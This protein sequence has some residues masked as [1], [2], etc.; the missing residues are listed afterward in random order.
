MS[1]EIRQLLAVIDAAYDRRSWHGTNLR[2]SIRGLT[3]RQAAWRPSPRGH[4][5]W[6]LVV[7]TAYWKYAALR[8][9]TGARRGSFSLKGSNWFARGAEADEHA[10]RD[11]VALL[12]RM[13]RSL[14]GAVAKLSAADLRR[15]PPGS[16]V[17]GFALLSG[18]AAH[19]LYHAGQIQLLKRLGPRAR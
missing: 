4:N 15:T 16:T 18:V 7:H 9:L 12:D 3:A 11:E 13:H 14:R 19:D 10:W 6:E 17:S 5:I 8:R 1:G 2:G